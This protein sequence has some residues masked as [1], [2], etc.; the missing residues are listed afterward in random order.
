VIERHRG[1]LESR[2]INVRQQ[3]AA[4]AVRCEIDPDHLAQAFA[5][6]L[7]NAIEAAPEASDIALT[8]DLLPSGAWRCRLTNGGASI[9]PEAVARAFE[10]FFSTKP[11]ATGI[12]L[13]LAQRIV[14]AHHGTI[15][16]E[17]SA[18]TGTTA[19]IILPPAG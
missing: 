11:G 18:T 3:H 7:E 19:T 10:I 13:A 1:Q 12:G 17:S 4:P 5:N 15:T 16:L 8:S 14:E 6:V 2:S 9:P